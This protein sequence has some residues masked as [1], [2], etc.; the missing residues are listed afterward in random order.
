MNE[1]LMKIHNYPLQPYHIQR[2][3]ERNPGGACGPTSVINALRNLGYNRDTLPWA[4]D[5]EQLEDTFYRYLH[6]PEFY[7]WFYQN[8][9]PGCKNTGQGHPRNFTVALTEGI[10]RLMPELRVSR[11]E[12]TIE[13]VVNSMENEKAIH[14]I[15]GDF[16]QS[17]HFVSLVGLELSQEYKVIN[18]I[19]DD[20]WG[21]WMLRYQHDSMGNIDGNN[22]RYPAGKL[23]RVTWKNKIYHPTIEFLP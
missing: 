17:G 20:S 13:E 21:D 16:T 7:A 23:Q 6:T 12:R 2:N 10:K 3:N 4:V 14:V 18:Y 19:V 9:C 22:R 1:N 11:K 5:G 8:V 15:G